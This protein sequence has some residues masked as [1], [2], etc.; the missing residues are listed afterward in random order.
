MA[1][2][3]LSLGG[4]LLTYEAINLSRRRKMIAPYLQSGG[5]LLDEGLENGGDFLSTCDGRGASMFLKVNLPK[6][7]AMSFSFDPDKKT[8]P[9]CPCRRNHP[10][11]GA[12][13]AS[14]Q[15]RA[16]REAF[17]LSPLCSQAAPPRAASG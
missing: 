17:L 1:A 8:C 5:T 15:E 16:E 11:L 6:K 4:K 10:V 12:P 9:F 14:S 7:M 13:L 3:R 2:I